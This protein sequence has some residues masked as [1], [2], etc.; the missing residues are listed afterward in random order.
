MALR[1]SGRYQLMKTG[2]VLALYRQHS[3]QTSR[4]VFEVDPQSRLRDSMLLRCGSVGPDSSA[5]DRKQLRDRRVAA[6][7][8]FA[9]RHA[10]GGH[11]RTAMGAESRALL[12]SPAN[13]RAWRTLLT[14]LVAVARRLPGR[15]A[16]HARARRE[17]AANDRTRGG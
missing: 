1:V 15:V 7:L 9:A 3:G 13:L 17:Q 11:L 12:A 6:H 4:R 2:D 8:S 14:V 16:R 10:L 5:C